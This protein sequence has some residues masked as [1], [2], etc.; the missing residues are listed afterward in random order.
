MWKIIIHV[1]AFSINLEMPVWIIYSSY[2]TTCRLK[3]W[4]LSKKISTFL[5]NTP[6]YL[7]VKELE[8][9]CGTIDATIYAYVEGYH[10]FSGIFS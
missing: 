8:S 5:K 6:K 1:V 2:S 10:P 4:H 7:L 9:Y 3:G